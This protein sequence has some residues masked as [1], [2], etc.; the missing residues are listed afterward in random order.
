LESD[1]SRGRTTLR[2]SLRTTS[3]ERDWDAG[4]VNSVTGLNIL[5]QLVDEFV[6]RRWAVA[7]DFDGFAI[8]SVDGAI[9]IP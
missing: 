7:W 6:L 8:R 4:V 3:G 2:V 1:D 9:A 5:D